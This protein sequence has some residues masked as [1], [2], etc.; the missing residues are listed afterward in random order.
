VREL[1]LI[2]TGKLEW[3]DRPD[4]VPEAPDDAIVRPIVVSRCDGDTLPI[5]RH[6]SRA[7]QAGLRT[8]VIDAAVGHICGAVPF[9]GPFAIGHECVGEVVDVGSAVTRLAVGDRVVVPWSVSCG[10]CDHC[11]RGLTSK[12][13]TTRREAAGERLLAAYGFGPA[14]GPYGGMVSDLVRVL[15]ADHMLVR[16]PDGLDPLRVAAASDNLADAWRTV[17]PHLRAR[18]GAR[19]LVVGGGGQSIGI[20]AA[21]LAVAHGAAAVDYVDC[22]PQRMQIAESLGASTHR[23]SR[24]STTPRSTYDIVVEAS[25]ST[26]GIRYAIRATAPGGICTAVGYYVAT[27][28]G[29][30]LMHMYANDITLHLGVSH[31]RA[32]LPELLDWVHAHDF[33]AERVTTHLASF[34]DAPAV[35]GVRT[36]K[37]VL[38][39]APLT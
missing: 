15:F 6:V 34:D 10:A 18:P 22:S 28:T 5:H 11:R 39:R 4:P 27:N 23:R 24:R 14:S 1:N 8:G 37:L 32:V 3:I 26:A 7:M 35:Y 19:V 9:A 38:R 12:C 25:S 30:P 36:T 17:V 21:G 13:L 2:A 16:L 29:I 31:P 33:P 20:Y